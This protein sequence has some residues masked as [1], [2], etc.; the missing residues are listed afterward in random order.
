MLVGH[1]KVMEHGQA[2]H[3]LA[4]VSHCYICS[5]FIVTLLFTI[6]ITA[7]P[8]DPPPVNCGDPGTPANGIRIGSDFS[9][10]SVVRYRCQ[11][12]FRLLGRS[13]RVC[14]TSGEWSNSL[15]DCVR[16][17]GNSTR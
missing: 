3:L 12:G 16:Q 13:E 4:N 6:H 8:T 1:V 11:T 7:A 14:Q 17:G 10:G 9:I 5:H 2:V 15:P